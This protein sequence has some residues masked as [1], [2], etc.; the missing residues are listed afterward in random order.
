MKQLV[1]YK[2]DEANTI[3]VEVELS[4]AGVDRVS[5]AGDV[6]TAAM[7]F[8]ETLEQIKP[9]VRTIA[10]QLRSLADSPDQFGVEFGI[11]LGAKAGVIIASADV[12]ANFKVSLSWTRSRPEATEAAP[13]TSQTGS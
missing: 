2:I 13:A 3:Y 10:S 6:V 7:T 11:K 4:E 12:E 1:E 9:L 5:R 8:D